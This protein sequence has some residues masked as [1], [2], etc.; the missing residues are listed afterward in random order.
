M[1]LQTWNS[2]FMNASPIFRPFEHLRRSLSEMQEWPVLPELNRLRAFQRQPILTRSGKEIC[3]VPAMTG[4]QS[5]EQKYE[6]KIFLTGEV[7]TRASNW[8]DFF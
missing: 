1:D 8:H 2:G 5:F 4:K 6:T 7:Q 3:F